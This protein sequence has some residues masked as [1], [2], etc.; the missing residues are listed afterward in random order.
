MQIKLGSKKYPA[1][2]LSFLESFIGYMFKFN[3]THAF[4]FKLGKFNSIHMWFVFF[5][6]NAIWLDNING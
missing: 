5:K 1:K 3:P 6:M 2:K 4:I